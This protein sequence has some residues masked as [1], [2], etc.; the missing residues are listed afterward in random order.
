[1][2]VV[3]AVEASRLVVLWAAGDAPA[4]SADRRLVG[5]DDLACLALD[6][7]TETAAV[8]AREKRPSAQD[9]AMQRAQALLSLPRGMPWISAS[10][11]DN[12]QA[13]ADT[14]S[15]ALWQLHQLHHLS[16]E[17]LRFWT[18]KK[19]GRPRLNCAAQD[20][21]RAGR[22]VVVP[23]PARVLLEPPAELGEGQACLRVVMQLGEE[24]ETLFLLGPP[25]REEGEEADTPSGMSRVLYPF[26]DLACVA[27]ASG[28]QQLQLARAPITIPVGALGTPGPLKAPRTG[29]RV[30]VSATIPYWT[31]GDVVAAATFLA[32]DKTAL[33][34]ESAA[35]LSE[36]PR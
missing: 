5:C 16:P 7:A 35:S 3:D 6:S 33:A 28:Q 31:N 23:W 11:R 22:L 32:G 19:A 36:A 4:G 13:F 27:P 21:M 25:A 18:A 20:D 8:A 24:Q 26:W 17:Q 34:T 10:P 14:L 30:H 12:R 2:G 9:L 1:L 29:S 15:S